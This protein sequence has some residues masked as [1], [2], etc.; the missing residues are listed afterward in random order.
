[1][2]RVPRILTDWLLVDCIPPD[3]ASTR[4]ILGVLT[5]SADDLLGRPGEPYI[6]SPLVEIDA[7]AGR[8][9]TRSGREL[10]LH[11]RA[12]EPSTDQH[13]ILRR[14][15]RTWNL[16]AETEWRVVREDDA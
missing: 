11:D 2:P 14:A 12:A 9:V 3:G 1:M 10:T 5:H 7:A 8:A 16:T 6:S 13:M 15:E 4:H